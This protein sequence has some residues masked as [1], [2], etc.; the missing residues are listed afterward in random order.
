MVIAGHPGVNSPPDPIDELDQGRV[1]ED[2]G[3]YCN[4]DA[5]WRFRER[6]PITGGDAR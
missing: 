6:L 3:T 4:I 2:K 1:P 5:G